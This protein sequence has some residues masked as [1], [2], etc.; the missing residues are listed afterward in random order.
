MKIENLSF[1]KAYAQ[2]KLGNLKNPYR[3]YEY[4]VD[5]YTEEGYALII[6]INSF[7]YQIIKSKLNSINLLQEEDIPDI[8]INLLKETSK[9]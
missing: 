4:V 5:E 3:V 2:R 9:K 8:Y 7:D 1:L 6:N